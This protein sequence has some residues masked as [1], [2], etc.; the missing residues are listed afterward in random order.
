MPAAR[1]QPHYF[2]RQTDDPFEANLYRG[3]S[4]IA[5]TNFLTNTAK[6]INPPAEQSSAHNLPERLT[7]PHSQ[8]IFHAVE[9]H[10]R[11]DRVDDMRF[12]DNEP[13]FLN[14]RM[15]QE[16]RAAE[17]ARQHPGDREPLHYI[18][19]TLNSIDSA[20][21]YNRTLFHLPISTHLINA[22]HEL[23][24]T[25]REFTAHHQWTPAAKDSLLRAIKSTTASRE[26]AKDHEKSFEHDTSFYLNCEKAAACIGLDYHQSLQ[27][28]QTTT[29]SRVSRLQRLYDTRNDQK[30]NDRDR[31]R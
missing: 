10:L 8:T 21:Y 25:L 19:E 2:W 4:L 11:I 28:T 18:R 31:E 16:Q 15:E 6:H 24:Q 7:A 20:E 3:D 29:S 22:R 14:T 12:S 9:Q 13:D 17:F 26:A 23:Q 5:E 27:S 1:D 30:D